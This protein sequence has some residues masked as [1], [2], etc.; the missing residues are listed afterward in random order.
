[1]SV[2]SGCPVA[3]G[4]AMGPYWTFV[5]VTFCAVRFGLAV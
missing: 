3:V 1:L 2:M 5:K 4:A